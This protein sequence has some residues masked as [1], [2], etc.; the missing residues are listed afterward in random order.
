MVATAAPILDHRME[1]TY[2]EGQSNKVE[3]A[4]VSDAMGLRVSLDC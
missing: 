2:E 4:R 3:G 1:A